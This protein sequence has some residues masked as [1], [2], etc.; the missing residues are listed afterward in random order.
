MRQEEMTSTRR[1]VSPCSSSQTRRTAEDEEGEQIGCTIPAGAPCKVD[2]DAINKERDTEKQLQTSS[3][4]F[5]PDGGLGAW[6]NC[7]AASVSFM[8]S[9]GIVNAYGVFQDYYKNDRLKNENESIIALIGA[10][11]LFILYGT[12]PMVGKIFDSFGTRIIYP[13]GSFLIVF[14]LMMVS[15][16]KPDQT[17]Q[18][19]LAQ[20]VTFGLGCALLFTPGLALMGHYF[21][22]KRALAI[23]FVAAGSSIGG[24]IFPIALQRL[25]PRIGFG[26][27]VRVMAFIALGCLTFS[28]IIAKTYLP[29]RKTTT[30]EVLRAIDFGGFKDLRYTLATLS[31]FVTFYAIFI[32]YFYIKQYGQLRGMSIELSNYLLPL[33]NA[34]GVPSRIAPGLLAPKFGVLNLMIFFTTIAGI[35]ILALWL[36]SSNNISIIWFSALYGLFSGPYISLLPAYIGII[37]PQPV[38]GA[39]LGALYLIV[40]VACLVG[41]PTGGAL[42]GS[43]G[44]LEHYRH[45]IGFSGALVL[46]GSLILVLIWFVEARLMLQRR[47]QKGDSSPLRLADFRF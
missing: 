14:G 11:Q 45:L 37:S 22:R 19:F 34:L 6:L 7:A 32:P 26:W 2:G 42:V 30:R 1:D 27:A 18:Y 44:D 17:Y 28:C 43:K 9:F 31:A 40:A 25:I 12:A 46:S 10:I 39:R 8:C 24:V 21:R 3:L 23:G 16:A 15:L 38:Y 36:P 13:L 5:V 33:I 20:A 29:L 4:P 41:T 47:K 35:L